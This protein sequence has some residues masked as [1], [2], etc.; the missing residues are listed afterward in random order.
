MYVYGKRISR[1]Q[2]NIGQRA[3]R[4]AQGPA[5]GSPCI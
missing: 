2:P 5:I 4:E 1:E 3:Y